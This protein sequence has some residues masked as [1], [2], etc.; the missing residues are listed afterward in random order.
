MNPFDGKVF[1]VGRTGDKLRNR[2]KSHI[3]GSKRVK[4]LKNTIIQNIMN[5]GETPKII[6]L[7]EVED[8]YRFGKE[9]GKR[10]RYWIEQFVE[11]EGQLANIVGNPS[12]WGDV[13]RM[14]KY[15]TRNE[16]RIKFLNLLKSSEIF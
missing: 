1:Y 3:S 12:V 13:H 7:E 10:E 14:I 2:L 16:K 15:G 4:S 8:S 6:L 9:I 5:N 11:S